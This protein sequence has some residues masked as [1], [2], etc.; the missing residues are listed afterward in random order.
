MA[1]TMDVDIYASTAL[2]SGMTTVMLSFLTTAQV[3]LTPENV[4][5]PVGV[6]LS[7]VAGTFGL[8]IWSTI[9]AVRTFDRIT[10]NQRRIMVKLELKEDE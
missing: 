4:W 1:R 7:F 3:L 10:R 2:T 5:V 8:A 9:R 6:A